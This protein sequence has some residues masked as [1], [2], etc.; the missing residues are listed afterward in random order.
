MQRFARAIDFIEEHLEDA[1]SL[2]SIAKAAGLSTYHLHVRFGL[3]PASL[4]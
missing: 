2:E 1:L 3:C 4:S